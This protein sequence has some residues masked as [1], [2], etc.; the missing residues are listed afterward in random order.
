MKIASS[1]TLD[2][3]ATIKINENGGKNRSKYVEQCVKAYGSPQQFPTRQL[4]AVLLTRDDVDQFLK[5]KILER[6]QS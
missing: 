5:D 4:Y 2:L 6:L 3:E 1:F